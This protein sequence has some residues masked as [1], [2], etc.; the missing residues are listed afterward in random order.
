LQ[1]QPAQRPRRLDQQL[2]RF[3]GSHS[4][5][6]RQYAPLLVDALDLADIPR[7]IADVLDAV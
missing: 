7:P 6:K 5:R 1:Q 4:G 3:M 2:R